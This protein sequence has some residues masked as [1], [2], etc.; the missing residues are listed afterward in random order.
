M[1]PYR[2]AIVGLGGIA[3]QSHLPAFRR[4][5]LAERFHI[6]GAVDPA[7]AH[8]RVVDGLRVYA[9]TTELLADN[10][11]DFVDIATPSAAHVALA[12]WALEQGLHVL[13]EKPVAVRR[14]D[15]RALA[16]VAGTHSR[17]LMACHQ[18]RANPVWQR[19]RRWLADGA[20]GEWHLCEI[21]VYRTQAD[22]GTSADALPW[23][24]RKQ[25]AGGGILLDHGTH[26]LYTVLD[27]GA[28]PQR[29]SA[30]TSTLVHRAY[31][32][33]DTAEIRLEFPSRVATLFLTWAARHRETR[34]HIVG[35]RGSITW[36]D[37]ALT[38]ERD[39][40]LETIDCSREL[41]KASY[42]GW[43]VDLF[44]RFAD[45]LDEGATSALA[46]WAREDIVRVATVLEG[47]Y[48]SAEISA[49][50]PLD[51]LIDD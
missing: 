51:E 18:Y 25:D 47:A 46:D 10:D 34:V 35:E 7:R 1:R 33:E 27:L 42:A 19:I 29:I 41:D 14:G 20:I 22:R 37:G 31:E 9:D 2:G 44:A 50:V 8:E 15:A 48:R 3:T 32:V 13:C 28:V 21:G 23:R 17:V 36:I 11:I 24:V 40:R 45:A 5:A 26:L 43:F 12:R 4:P 38:L 39:G 30:W 16:N 49:A 6:V